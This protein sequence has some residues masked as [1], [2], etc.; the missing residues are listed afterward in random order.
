MPADSKP[1]PWNRLYWAVAGYTLIL[2]LLLYL[3][4]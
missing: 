4:S 2:T 3:I 1:I